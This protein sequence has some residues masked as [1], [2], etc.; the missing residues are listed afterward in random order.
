MCAAA[1]KARGLLDLQRPRQMDMNGE[2][3]VIPA[4][5]KAKMPPF[6]Q[7]AEKSRNRVSSCSGL[8]CVTAAILCSFCSILSV[9]GAKLT[10][11]QNAAAAGDDGGSMEVCRKLGMMTHPVSGDPCWQISEHRASHGFRGHIVLHS[12]ALS[13]L[14]NRHVICPL[15]KL[16]GSGL[17]PLAHARFR[18]VLADSTGQPRHAGRHAYAV[19]LRSRWV[20]FVTS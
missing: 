14:E 6:S 16:C 18:T 1:A 11:M 7:I 13:T 19:H 12:L 8:Q 2:H 3:S 15:H 17:R 4:L 10:E 9:G 5:S 20:D